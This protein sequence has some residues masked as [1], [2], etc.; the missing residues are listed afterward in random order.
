MQLQLLPSEKIDKKK[1]NE[2]L[3]N[4]SNQFIYASSDYLDCMADNWDGIIAGNYELIM[5]VTWRKKFGIKY[6]YKVPFMQQLG[7]FGKTFSQ[8]DIDSCIKLMQESFKYGDYYFNNLNNVKN[9]SIHS[10]YILSL[11]SNYRS[12]SF[13]YTDKLKA[14]LSKVKNNPL[15]YELSNAHEAVAIFR[16]LYAEKIPEVSS[17]DYDNFSFLCDIKKKENN[18]IV[19]KIS[20]NKNI[21]AIALLLKDKFRIYNLLSC[22][23]QEGRGMF[24]GHFL[25]DSIIKEYSQTGL[26]FDFEGSEIPGVKHFYKS[27]GAI[28]QPYTKLHFNKLPYPLRIL[29]R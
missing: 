1:W 12:I 8:H 5:P 4:S 11:A 21:L 25:Y 2:C 19:R 6:C 28:N 15:H 7:V 24:A 13:F 20:S 27:F 9:G 23:T 17:T 14:D 10:N 26:I 29:K 18:L 22:T 3:N 16:S